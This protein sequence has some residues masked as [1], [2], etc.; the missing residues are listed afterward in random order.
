MDLIASGSVLP[1]QDRSLDYLCASH[2]LEHLPDPIGAILEWHRV[3]SGGGY[4]YLV[5]PDKEKTFDRARKITPLPHLVS[6]FLDD[7]VVASNEE[8][9]SF[10]YETDWAIL[11]PH[12]SEERRPYDQRFLADWY[13]NET[14]SGKAVDIHYHVFTHD[15]FL[16]LFKE[17]ALAKGFC[18]LF[19]IVGIEKEYPKE[20]G[21]GIG[22]LL[23]KR[24]RIFDRF[25]AVEQRTLFLEKNGVTK[26]LYLVTAAN[27]GVIPLQINS[28]TAE[29]LRK[30]GIVIEEGVPNMRVDAASARRYFRRQLWKYL[31]CKCLVP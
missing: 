30:Y 21:D 29:D 11:Q 23:K 14:K 24:A 25:N 31:F 4:L 3:L 13:K 18:R 20:R 8:I 12:I 7:V 2:V 1:L 28:A 5:V 27:L 26:R 16:D 15:S 19:D 10:I 17:T 22:I 6:D 9:D